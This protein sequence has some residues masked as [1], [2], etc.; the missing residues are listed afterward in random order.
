MTLQKTFN[1]KNILIIGHTGFK[2]SWLAAWLKQLGAKVVGIALDPPTEPS[3]FVAAQLAVVIGW[4]RGHCLTDFDGRYRAWTRVAISWLVIA[5]VVGTGAHQSISQVLLVQFGF[6][7]VW[8]RE[9]L[10]W[11]LPLA[12]LVS[13]VA[14]V[15]DGEM[16]TSR[17]A[18]LLLWLSTAT[19]VAGLA[20]VL[21]P[22]LINA[23]VLELFPQLVAFLKLQDTHRG[24]K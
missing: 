10:A 15:M 3:H 21:E 13:S 4:V 24:F 2:G 1:A 11:L 16:K 22:T 8:Q 9:V 17:T 14:W 23:E 20:L 12:A 6:E 18:R 5:G 19:A 7:S